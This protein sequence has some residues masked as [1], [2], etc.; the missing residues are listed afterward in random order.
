LRGRHADGAAVA[1][2]SRRHPG[3]RHAL[4]FFFF[5][6]VLGLSAAA[7]TAAPAVRV[8]GTELVIQ[9]GHGPEL[10]SRDL[11]G[12]QLGLTIDG[13]PAVVRIDAVSLEDGPRG[14]LFWLHDF[15]LQHAD[16]SWR[17]LCDVAA[18]GRRLALALAGRSRANGSLDPREPDAIA[19]ACLAGAQAKCVRYGYT[20]WGQAPDG[21]SLRA[22]HGACV[23]MLRADYAADGGTA[24]RDGQPVGSTDRW[25]LRKLEL[26][27]SDRFEAGWDDQ[28][29]VCVRR[30][31]LADGLTLAQL[32]ARVPRLKG[33]TGAAC[34][35][36]AAR[37]WGA[38]ILN[39]LPS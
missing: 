21:R 5:G 17:P 36:E 30:P 1:A 3:Q 29:A 28:G 12:A 14:L 37:S 7:Q 31:R 27:A 15:S 2:A 32:E 23:A 19:I 8:E 26:S 34:T 18:D 25:G 6:A 16:G 24:T 38:L 20:P 39:W 13:R 11:V 4:P 35:P 10:R 9:A 33:R 22:A